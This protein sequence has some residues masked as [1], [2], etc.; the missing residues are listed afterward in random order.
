M[1]SR[2]NFLKSTKI[3]RNREKNLRNEKNISEL[4]KLFQIRENYFKIEKN[5]SESRNILL[6]YS[7]KTLELNDFKCDEPLS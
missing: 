3:F 7:R 2:T 5:V 1:K 6:Q 4:R